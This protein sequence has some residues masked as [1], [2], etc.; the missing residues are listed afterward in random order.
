M[1]TE[2]IDYLTQAIELRPAS[3]EWLRWMADWQAGS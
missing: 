2:A 3:E 1:N